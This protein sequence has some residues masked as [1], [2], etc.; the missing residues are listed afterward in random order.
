MII[1]KQH[2]RVLYVFLLSFRRNWKRRWFVLKDNILTYH[3]TDV[4]GAKSLGTIDIKNAM[5][6]EAILKPQTVQTFLF[7]CT[8]RGVLFEWKGNSGVVPISFGFWQYFLRVDMRLQT[9]SFHNWMN[10]KIR[11]GLNFVLI[12]FQT[13]NWRWCKREWLQHHYR[14]QDLSCYCREHVWLEVSHAL[15]CSMFIRLLH[16]LCDLLELICRRR[17]HIRDTQ[18]H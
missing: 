7:K 18:L 5:Y 11:T 6:V 8:R 12:F 9:D 4:E 17:V 10:C 1:F 14:K 15:F 16:L 2:S 13:H 3:E